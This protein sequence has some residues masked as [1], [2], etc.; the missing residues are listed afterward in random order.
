MPRINNVVL[1]YAKIKNP[2]LEFE[3]K[4]D[5]N[6][7]MMNKEYVVDCVIPAKAF[8]GIKKTFK[9][10]ASIKNARSLT[11]AEYEDIYKVAPP[12]GD[13]YLNADGEINILKF[14]KKAYYKDGKHTTPVPVQGIV[15]KNK[16][17]KGLLV[18]QDVEIGN[19][20]V[21]NLQF[22]ER[23]WTF[24]GKN[25]LSLDLV[26]LQILELVQYQAAGDDD[27]FEYEEDPEGED[28]EFDSEDDSTGEAVEATS[29]QGD[30]QDEW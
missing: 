29:T 4:A 19:G 5:P 26:R 28:N 8:K 25:G 12:A 9:A 7:A 20:T 11:P 14:K 24:G 18:G 17:R 10:V 21:A 2:G 6:N 3:A 13:D 1:H 15:G 16:D 30:S 22:K 27:E 23:P